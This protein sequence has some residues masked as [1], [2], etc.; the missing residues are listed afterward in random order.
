MLLVADNDVADLDMVLND[1]VSVATLCMEIP[2]LILYRNNGGGNSQRS[3][4]I[5]DNILVVE[6]VPYDEHPV[7]HLLFHHMLQKL[8]DLRGGV[9]S[10]GVS[11]DKIGA[12]FRVFP[13][14]IVLVPEFLKARVRVSLDLHELVVFDL[15]VEMCVVLLKGD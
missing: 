13:G 9:G 7:H 15:K 2:K 6:V 3:D 1:V 4:K 10:E 5:G 12:F 14:E 11:Y 8:E